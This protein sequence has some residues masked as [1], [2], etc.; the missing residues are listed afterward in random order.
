MNI[1]TKELIGKLK[2]E[3]QFLEEGGYSPSVHEPHKTQRV[4]RDSVSCPNL[5]SELKV[6]PCSSCYLIAFVPPEH[7]EKEDA[8]HYIPLNAK[9]DTAVSLLRDGGED[10]LQGALRTWLKSTIG[11]LEREPKAKETT[12]SGRVPRVLLAAGE[13]RVCILLPPGRRAA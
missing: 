10:A 12:A 6:E 7:R 11:W 2:L 1:E 3:L 13:Q 4:F 5:G 8:C 9:G